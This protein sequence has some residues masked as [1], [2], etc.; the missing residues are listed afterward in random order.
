M[1]TTTFPIAAAAAGAAGAAH[2]DPQATT[3][4]AANADDRLRAQVLQRLTQAPGWRPAVSN[5]YVADGE[6]LLQGIVAS[7]AERR[8]AQVLAS[9]V[10]GVRS[11]RDA[12][13]ARPDWLSMA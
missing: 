12:R 5:V 4:P 10:S 13:V 8:R 3:P 9:A 1:S 11:V 7:S 2:A 6:V